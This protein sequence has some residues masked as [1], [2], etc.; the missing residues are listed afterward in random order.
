M[1]LYEGGITA[2]QQRKF[3]IAAK[4]LRQVV[5]DYPEERELHERA[6]LYI[7]V[8]ERESAPK[9]SAPETTDQRIYAATLA[10]NGGVIDEALRH[11]NAAAKDKP[12]SAHIQY[13]LAIAHA[14]A[15]QAEPA[16]TYLERA[17]RLNDDNR[18]LAR[19]EP[20]FESLHDDERFQRVTASDEAGSSD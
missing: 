18:L 16:I 19:Q 7:A 10:L 14:L 6:R 5:N 11:L 9:A 17:I 20:D 8:C 2:I 13:M 3:D 4:R 12:D 15:D 1:K